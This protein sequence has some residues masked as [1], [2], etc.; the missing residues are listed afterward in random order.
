MPARNAI[1][2]ALLACASSS[3]SEALCSSAVADA[4]LACWWIVYSS[5]PKI[6]SITSWSRC[7]MSTSSPTSIALNS[8]RLAAT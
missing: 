7:W 8:P 1:V 2:I 4:A 6:G 3:R 5:T